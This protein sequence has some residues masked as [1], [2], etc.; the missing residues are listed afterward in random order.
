L[1]QDASALEMKLLDFL[2]TNCSNGFSS[3]DTTSISS[4]PD[5]TSSLSSSKQGKI[6][7]IPRAGLEGNLEL[8]EVRRLL[9]HFDNPHQ[10]EGDNTLVTPPTLSQLTIEYPNSTSSTLIFFLLIHLPIS[11]QMPSPENILTSSTFSTQPL[12]E[13]SFLAR[14]NYDEL[15]QLY[16]DMIEKYVK[17]VNST[18]SEDDSTIQSSVDAINFYTKLLHEIENQT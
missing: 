6:L 15:F 5:Q 13:L 2:S 7:E 14:S 11:D 10:H 1:V 4:N 3:F 8:K 12:I 16:R 9:F 18:E 17:R